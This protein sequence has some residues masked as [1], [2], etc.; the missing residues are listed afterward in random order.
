MPHPTAKNR[1]ARWLPSVIA[2]AVLIGAAIAASLL[3]PIDTAPAA[4]APP[5]TAP[6]VTTAFPRQQ[7][8]TFQGRLAR[9]L[10]GQPLPEEIYDVAV[11]TFPTEIQ[12]QLSDGITV[13][14]EEELQQWL[15]NFTS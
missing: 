12:Q 14:S 10:E 5:T 7:L 4:E 11:R 13:R 1:T 2:C 3:L 9:F 6:T 8:K 15:D